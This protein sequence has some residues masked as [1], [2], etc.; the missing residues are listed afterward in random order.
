MRADASLAADPSIFARATAARVGSAL[1]RDLLSIEGYSAMTLEALGVDSL[2]AI[3]LRNWWRATFATEVS[4]LEL[5]Q[6]GL[7]IEGI[8]RLGARRAEES[9][10][11]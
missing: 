7:T 6:G 2:F 1:N 3:E 10:R 9:R 4:V 11:Q 5:M 8:G